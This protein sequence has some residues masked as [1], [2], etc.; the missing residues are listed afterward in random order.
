MQLECD[1]FMKMFDVDSDAVDLKID[2]IEWINER[3]L[4]DPCFD[5]LGPVLA[6]KS[7]LL[8]LSPVSLQGNAMS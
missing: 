4:K 2:L 3:A 1:L 6:P 7:L 5:F 8:P